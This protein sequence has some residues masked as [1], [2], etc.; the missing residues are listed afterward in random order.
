MYWRTEVFVETQS[1]LKKLYGILNSSGRVKVKT[2]KGPFIFFTKDAK[3]YGS[4]I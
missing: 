2:N 3:T 1:D 4:M